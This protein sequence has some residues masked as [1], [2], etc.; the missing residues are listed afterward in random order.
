MAEEPYVEPWEPAELDAE[1]EASAVEVA[2][3]PEKSTA[4]SSEDLDGEPSFKPLQPVKLDAAPEASA[5]EDNLVP[6]FH[7]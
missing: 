3:L 6:L 2:E 4:P 5:E 7:I 1:P